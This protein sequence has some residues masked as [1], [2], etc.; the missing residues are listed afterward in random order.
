MRAGAVVVNSPLSSLN[1]PLMRVAGID[2]RSFDEPYGLAL[3]GS[4]TEL[5][6]EPRCAGQARSYL[7]P[8]GSRVGSPRRPANRTC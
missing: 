1:S 3:S 7:R 5:W 6:W 4:E 8:P 2:G